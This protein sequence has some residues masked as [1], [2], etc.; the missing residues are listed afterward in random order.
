VKMVTNMAGA[1]TERTGYAVFGEP[2][3][4]TSLPKG[5]IGERPDVETGLLNL[6]ARLY[7]PALG[8]FISPDDWDPTLPGVGTN[9]YAY[10]GNDPVNKADANGHNWLTNTLSSI[11]SSISSMFTTSSLQT[12]ANNYM[13]KN[14]QS[15]LSAA[16]NVVTNTVKKVDNE[17]GMKKIREGI[18]KKKPLTFIEGVAI[19]GS[20]FLGGPGK[21]AG[22]E[23]AIAN[24]RRL[25]AIGENIVREAYEIGEKVA[26]RI[27]G[28]LRFPDGLTPNKVNEVKNV[29]KLNATAQIKAYANFATDSGR[30]LTVYTRQNTVIS[31]AIADMIRNGDLTIIRVPG[32]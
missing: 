16:Q 13:S 12:I 18:D 10:A 8:R 1:V 14:A 27:D 28:K 26:V 2:V 9:R 5:F 17:S 7:D 31:G 29:A 21:K 19:F 20:N 6:N 11:A 32:L 23:L 30:D 25:G 15:T 3:P 4:G 22:A 24:A